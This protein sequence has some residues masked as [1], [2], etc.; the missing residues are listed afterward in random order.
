M[1]DI[2]DRPSFD[3][4]K[5]WNKEIR[6]MVGDD[7]KICI[8]IVGNKV[9][10]ERQSRAVDSKEAKKYADSVGASFSEVSAKTGFGVEDVFTTLTRKMLDT[11]KPTNLTRSTLA[12]ASSSMSNS[13]NCNRGDDRVDLSIYDN[14]PSRCC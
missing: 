9:D 3:R 11:V 12:A 2:T 5:K 13:I 14:E 7:T 6:K 1:Y 4:V 10:L 8:T